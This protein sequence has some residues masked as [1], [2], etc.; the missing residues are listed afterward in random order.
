[1]F[2]LVQT[3]IF[4]IVIDDCYVNEDPSS[5]DERETKNIVWSVRISLLYSLWDGDLLLVHYS[6]KCLSPRIPATKRKRERIKKSVVL[7]WSSQN[8]PHGCVASS[9][10][11]LSPIRWLITCDL[12]KTKSRCLFKHILLYLVYWKRC[13][14]LL[15]HL[16]SGSWPFFD[17]LS[18][19]TFGNLCFQCCS[20]LV[21][22]CDPVWEKEI[23][24]FKP[25]IPDLKIDLVSHL[26]RGGGGGGGG[27]G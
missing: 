11:C 16:S 10:Q 25:T 15:I 13:R 21:V 19:R 12:N 3:G 20:S 23:S 1:M 2:N 17:E 6:C 14:I 26:F 7:Y 9:S 8:N 22:V 5:D 24:E 18:I 27:V 4:S